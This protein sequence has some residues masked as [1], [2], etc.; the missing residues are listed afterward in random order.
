M[1]RSLV[2]LS[3]ALLF[4]GLPARH[5]ASPSPFPS[6]VTPGQFAS[7]PFIPP[8]VTARVRPLPIR[9]GLAN[10]AN[11]QQMTRLFRFTPEQRQMLAKNGF[12]VTPGKEEQ[13][14]YV[15]ENNDYLV[16]P[17]FVTTDTVLQVY[18]V[19]YDFTLRKVEQTKLV[20]ELMTMAKG[21]VEASA[22]DHRDAGTPFVREAAKRNLAYAAV[23]RRLIDPAAPIPAE[24]ADL[25]NAELK[26]I[27]AHEGR[28]E[29]PIF[30]GTGI[31]ID[32]SQFVPRGHYTRTEELKR[33]FGAMMWLGL[34]PFPLE[35]ASTAAA[36]RM[37]TEQA[38]LLT[39]ALYEKRAEGTP[40]I[41]SWDKIY[42]PT[43]FYV[44]TADDLTPVEYHELAGRVLGSAGISAASLS[45]DSVDGFTAEA[46][47]AFRK[48][49]IAASIGDVTAGTVQE[50]QFRLMGQRFII[51][52]R[53]FQELT[54]PKVGTYNDRRLMPSGLDVMAAFGSKRATALQLANRASS[55][56]ENYGSQLAK[57]TAEIAAVDQETWTSN[58]YW[59]W[60]W[61]LRSLLEPAGEGYPSFMRNQ[62]WTDKSLS[63]ALGSWAE[64]KHDTVLYGKQSGAE[65]GGGDEPPIVR[66]YVEPNVECYARLQYLTTMSR[67][68]LR[69]RALIDEGDAVD[70]AFQEFDDLLAF[71]RNVSEK[72]L[73]NEALTRQ[74][75]DQIRYIGGQIER[76]T[77]SVIDENLTGW[78]EIESETDKNMAVVA[79]VHTGG[80]EALQ[81]GVGHADTIW[82]VAPIEG[83]LVLCRGA[84][85]SYYEFGHPVSDRLTDEKWQ[86]LLK[87]RPAPA[88][89]PWVRGFMSTAPAGAV[90]PSEVAVYS[91][92]C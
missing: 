67:Q 80:N 87:Q 22:R 75:Y 79:D 52:S 36:D 4:L 16:I 21:L 37:S 34:M 39:A 58:L 23:T 20:P 7:R 1:K 14:F 69:E 78:F 6:G 76:L 12:V 50:R 44:G 91:S 43:A 83:R 24:V 3:L 33:F 82:V 10:V 2:L 5:E 9:P 41:A 63:T 8:R 64:L 47:K 81:V 29:S 19:F 49:G 61:T 53:V 85:F 15:Y 62:A 45:E 86:G 30:T 68:G 57:M 27:E 26:L 60:L 17:S 73:R 11:L 13:L 72:Q 51:D 65:C 56:F 70:S 77:L 46:R 71:L 66:G 84:V 59:S 18:H 31:N 90:K 32:Y 88:R 42:A 89:P 25:V 48:P 35:N 40:L 92:G 38:M 54:F 28:A 74:E 55:G